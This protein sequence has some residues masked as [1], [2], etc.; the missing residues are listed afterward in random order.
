MNQFKTITELNNFLLL[1]NVKPVI[2]FSCGLYECYYNEKLIIIT[3]D[4]NILARDLP[5]TIKSNNKILHDIKLQF[6]N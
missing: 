3:A 1:R 6:C 5:I 4:L 2:W